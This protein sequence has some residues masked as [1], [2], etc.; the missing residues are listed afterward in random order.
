MDGRVRDYHVNVC[1]PVAHLLLNQ[2][3]PVTLLS[4]LET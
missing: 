4:D 3:G 1:T 2:V